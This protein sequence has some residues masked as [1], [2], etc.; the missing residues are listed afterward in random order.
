MLIGSK[1]SGIDFTKFSHKL[2]DSMAFWLLFPLVMR[3]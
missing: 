3:L 1:Y 2:M